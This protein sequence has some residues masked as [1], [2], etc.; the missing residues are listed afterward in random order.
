M[1]LDFTQRR[2]GRKEKI[3]LAFFASLRETAAQPWARS[4]SRITLRKVSSS[5]L[6]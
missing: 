2:K 6:S 1:I 3:C 5:V 4:S